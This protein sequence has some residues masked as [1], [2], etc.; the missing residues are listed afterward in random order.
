MKIDGSTLTQLLSSLDK[1]NPVANQL[2]EKISKGL[3]PVALLI[4]SVLM[5]VEFADTN[6]RVQIEQGRVNMELVFSIAWKYFVGFVLV[7]YSNEI[8]D[9][10][11]WLANAI[12]NIINNVTTAK[13]DLKF[14]VPELKGK[15]KASQKLIL[16][17]ISAV[18]HFSNWIA[19]IITKILVFLRAFELFIFKAV[20]KILVAAYVSEEWRPIAT[21]FL[22]KFMAIAIQGFLLILILKLYPALIANDMFDLVANGN[23]LQN[24]SAIF[25]SLCKSVVFI[26]VLI[27]SQ[28]KAKEWMGG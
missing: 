21:G 2:V 17:G 22:K 13:T 1:Y 23:Y 28:R 10:I 15:V 5:Y 4:L 20:A 27:G 24:L 8:F 25:M 3:T 14:V 7:M 16:N 11:V 6:K 9:S 18:A 19:E 12:G 26:L